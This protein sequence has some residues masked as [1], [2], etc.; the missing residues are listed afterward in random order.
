[1]ETVEAV[2]DLP[3]PSGYSAEEVTDSRVMSHVQQS[4]ELVYSPLVKNALKSSCKPEVACEPVTTSLFYGHKQKGTP[5][6]D[7]ARC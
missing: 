3:E 5:T 1:V 6:V 2:A 4:N 7:C